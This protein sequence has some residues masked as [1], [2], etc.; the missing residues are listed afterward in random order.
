MRVA[1]GI[2]LLA[3]VSLVPA[4]ALPTGQPEVAT[5]IDRLG[6]YDFQVRVD[7]AR[8]LRRASAAVA[9]P[10]LERAARSHRDSYVRFRALV[11]LSG[12][13]ETAA[14]RVTR[15]LLADSNDRVRAAAYQWFEHHPDRNVL[16][17]LIAALNTERSEFVRPALTRAIAAQSGDPRASAALLPLVSKGEDMFRGAVIEAL[18]D[19]KTRVALPAI[20]DVARLDG[21]LQD[22]AFTAVGKIGDK[23]T[24][25]ALR[26]LQPRVG[27]AVQPT[28]AATFCLLGVQCDEQRAYLERTLAYAISAD[29]PPVVRSAVHALG[30]LAGAG[31]RSALDI[32]LDTGNTS[33]ERVR[34]PIALV[35]GL[36]ALRSPAMMVDA[37]ERRGLRPPDLE[38]LRDAFDMLSE[39]FEEERFYAELRR[40]YWASAA[41]TVR[42][43]TADV[44]L[45][46]LEF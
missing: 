8:T 28:L 41:G 29:D 4:H 13:D 42:R 24:I 2:L 43:R 21:P 36:L 37:L 45:A 46:A 5:A 44:L 31:D 38:V 27:T 23:T 20:L 32:L 18:G 34:S 9:V 22:D 33:L 3:S 1:V 25:T 15:D 12:L 17:A 35:A 16:A 30:M 6:A 19:H 14:G 40:Q 39:E 11:L 7:A 10:A 26:E